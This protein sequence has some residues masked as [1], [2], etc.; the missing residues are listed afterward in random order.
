MKRTTKTTSKG[1]EQARQQLP[2]ILAEAAAGHAT[3]ITRRG[4]EVAAIVPIDAARLS[5]PMPL[6]ALAGTGRG[7]WGKRS[8]QTVARLRDEW[9]R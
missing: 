6:T 4:R 2:A 1:A 7:L 5:K 9:N 8:A 3:V